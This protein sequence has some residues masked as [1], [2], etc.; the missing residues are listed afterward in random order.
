MLGT[1]SKFC[2]TSIWVKKPQID[3]QQVAMAFELD[4]TQALL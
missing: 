1:Q 4:A 3:L 2:L